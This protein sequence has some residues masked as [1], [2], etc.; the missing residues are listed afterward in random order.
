MRFNES[1]IAELFF[2]WDGGFELRGVIHRY[3]AVIMIIASLWHFFF[4][5]TKRGK[6]FVKDMIPGLRD[7]R[8]FWEMVLYF[9]DYRDHEPKFG[10]FAYAEKLEY[11]AGVWGNMVMIATGLVLWFDNY[12]MQLFSKDLLD[13]SLVIHYWEAWLATLAILIWHIYNTI[14]RPSVAPM[15]TSWLTGSMPKQMFDHEHGGAEPDPELNPP[16]RD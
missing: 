4:L 13:I 5:F 14:F 11:W 12:F 3:A 10:R 1:W 15:N 9:F 8:E 2:G 7:I 6:G 16:D